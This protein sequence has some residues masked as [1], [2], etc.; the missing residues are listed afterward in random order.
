MKPLVLLFALLA[1]V[2]GCS[3]KEPTQP[4]S[5]NS[6]LGSMMR[7][8]PG[9]GTASQ[10][11]YEP[12]YVN[13]NT[14]WINAID[15]PNHA[16]PKAQAD[17]YE[18]VY[19]IGWSSLGLSAPQCNPCDHEGNGIDFTDYHDHILDS[20]PGTGH[21]EFSPLWHVFVVIPAYNQESTH[22]AAV[23]QAYAAY[24]PT[25]SEAQV[26]ALL[27]ARDANGAPIAVEIDTHFYF[28]CAVVHPPK[29]L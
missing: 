6:T 3:K 26:D 15:V 21:G 14:V 29:N 4:T 1:L 19:P 20:V 12:A 23:S 25:K 13:G 8:W 18:V 5:T 16:P 11:G 27:A 10:P 2:S 28:L 7:S 17:F 9:A 24:L 22:D